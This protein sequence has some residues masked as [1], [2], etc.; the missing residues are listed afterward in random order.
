MQEVTDL[1]KTWEEQHTSS[2][3]DPVPT[4]SRLSEIIETETENFMK[5]D[6]DPFDERH[7]SR[8]DP[9]CA[10]GHALKV[11]FKKD[12]FIN[13]LVNEYLHEKYYVRL[14]ISGRD[15][16]K[17]NVGACRLTLDLMPGLEMSAV[18]QDNEALIHRLASWAKTASEPLQCYATGLLAAAMDVQ[19]NATNYRDINVTLVPLMLQRLHVLRNQSSDDINNTV[20]PLGPQTRYFAR[21][22]KRRASREIH[23]GP[24][25][26]RLENGNDDGGGDAMELDP[27]TSINMTPTKRN[28]SILLS[29]ENHLMS[30]PHSRVTP[31]DHSSNS[32]W[33]EMETYVIGNIQ[34]HPPTNATKQMLIL[35]FLTP[36][37][38]YQEFLS[39]IFEQNALGL[40]LGYLNVKETKDSRLAFEALKYLASLLCHKKFSIDFI[41]M[42]G[43]QKFLDIPRPS[44]ASAG[45]SICLYYL[46]YCEDAMERVC[47][48]PR[49]T[50]GELVTYALWLLE[51]SHDS[52][53]SNATMF[54]GLSF[55]FKLILEEFDN[56]DGLRK[57][58]NVIS[59]LPILGNDDDENQRITEDE[60]S[61]ARQI[62]RHVCVALKRYLEAHLRA[63]AANFKRQAGECVPDLPP[64]KASRS[65]PE[66][67]QAQIELL[68]SVA[69]TRWPAVDDLVD[70]GGISLLLKVVGLGYDWNFTGRSE[71]LRSALDVV[72]VCSVSPRVQML[73]TEKLE[74]QSETTSGANIVLAA[75]SGEI[76]PEADVQK[77]A[78]NVLVNCVCAPVQRAGTSTARYS[79]TGSTKKRTALKSC[80]DVVQKVWESVRTNS[81]IMVLISL[82]MTKLPITDADRIR[83]LACRALAGLARCPTVRQIISKLPLFTSSQIQSLMRDPILQEKR[84]EHVMF[85]KYALELLERI[86]GKSKHMGPEFETSLVNIHKANVV[87]QTKINYNERQL[88]QLL[89]E[90]LTS[91]G[92]HESAAMLQREAG[93]PAL[94]AT[95]S[96]PPP[97]GVYTPSTPIRSRLN[98]RGNVSNI[99]KENNE[100]SLNTTVEETSSPHVIKLRKVQ[101]PTVSH[102]HTHEH[103]RSLQKQLSLPLAETCKMNHRI[104]L[105]NII[106]EYLYNQHALCK[107]PMVTCPQFNLFQPHKCP[108]PRRSQ[109]NYGEANNIV[110]R[111]ARREMYACTSNR[112]D[113]RL[114]HSH[115][116]ASRTLRLQDD[117]SYF[118]HSIYHPTKQQLLAATSNGDVHVFNLFSGNEE[119]CYSLFESYIYHMQANK[120]GTLLLAS[121]S[122]SWRPSSALYIL[123]DYEQKY[124]LDNEEYVE[125]SKINEDRIIGTLSENATI[126]DTAT[127]RKILH[128]RPTISNQYAKNRATFHPSDE[129]V[130]SDGVLWDVN[131]G[132]EIHK[133]DKLNQTHSGIFHPNGLEIISNT[134]VWDLRTFHLL[135]TVPTL[136][137]SEVIFNP[138]CTA[139]YA[140]CADQDA[141]EKS[142]VDTSFKTLDP[143]DYSSI[144]TVD[145]KRNIYSLQVSMLGAQIAVV[146]NVS[147]YE[148]VQESCVK[149]YEVGRRREQDDEAEEEDD[150][151][152][153]EGSEHDS[154][155][156]NEDA[157]ILRNVIMDGFGSG[158]DSSRESSGDERPQPRRSLRRQR[159][160]SGLFNYIGNK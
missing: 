152:L 48:L 12:T 131:T 117:E 106:T 73:L 52:G 2:N 118:T 80:E 74:V 36:F 40:I 53:R 140:I 124:Q 9:E 29:P 64:Y 26:G 6:P 159:R 89:Q 49:R 27:R 139:M 58:Y 105:H 148:Q 69:W 102:C 60:T 67:I 71:T 38:G 115:F 7:P 146:E 47:L 135:R 94:Q 114:A 84:Q 112:A 97:P 61:A 45:V 116:S 151:E 90:H 5:K 154:A 107:N 147:E 157:N 150:E 110:T 81:G 41:Q 134:E 30:P 144:A 70:L 125:F 155:S 87:A 33:A 54:F 31:H 141:D 23:N 130:L 142:Q 46:A 91:R 56:Q 136:D 101:N 51:C 57:L 43:L 20:P 3:Y 14:N 66:E 132:K 96:A 119:N 44:V 103:K 95:A 108:D 19:D 143:Y 93:L 138:T 59:T 1:L 158:D 15:V 127:G 123:G 77:A 122:N 153:E 109:L 50:L 85:Q 104:T 92:L 75:A 8:T 22:D 17:L 88:L 82:M 83:G 16:N 13:K 21:F 72:S 4:L 10:L 37:G 28:N 133:F 24:T 11:L 129:L 100:V 79:H 120:D 63:R 113:S 62:V 99:Y 128:L 156:D 78:L 86:S 68:Q 42:G 35:K 137:K 25:K 98:A 65:T 76:V 111:A 145:V 55:Q 34:I 18:F 32:S 121:S 39:H 160:V 149:L 126:F